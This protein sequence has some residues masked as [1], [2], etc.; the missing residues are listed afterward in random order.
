MRFFFCPILWFSL[1]A[2]ASA[3]ASQKL[4]ATPVLVFASSTVQAGES[5]DIAIVFTIEPGWHM[6]WLNPGDSGLPPSVLWELPAG[7]TADPLRFPTPHRIDTG[8]G[9]TSYGYEK[10]W[11]MLG[12]LNIPADFKGDSVGVR[13]KIDWLVCQE[14]CVLESSGIES[15]IHL[16]SEKSDQDS[17]FV[18]WRAA[19]P[20]SDASVNVAI[21]LT[22]DSDAGELKIGLPEGSKFL[23]FFPPP[24]DAAVFSG[25]RSTVRFANANL[26]VPFRILPG[27]HTAQ[28]A[29]AIIV[30]TDVTG[31]HAV[32][33]PVE[34]K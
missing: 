27:K 3:A 4:H 29:E 11:A 25:D 18:A 13:A 28:T 17:Q 31:V 20:V 16:G 22:A 6:Y 2:V 5:V 14:N 1:C 10:T 19:L 34:M 23:D 33:L 32:R 15:K 9:M 26:S 30:Y 24:L 12:R 21:C 8:N 7:V